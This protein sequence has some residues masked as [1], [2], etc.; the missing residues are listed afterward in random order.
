MVT[1]QTSETGFLW[2]IIVMRYEK[3]LQKQKVEV[4]T[5]FDEIMNTVIL[6]SQKSFSMRCE[7]MKV[8]SVSLQIDQGMTKDMQ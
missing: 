4:Y 1:D 8:T 5:I 2:K 3:Y 6:K 7:K